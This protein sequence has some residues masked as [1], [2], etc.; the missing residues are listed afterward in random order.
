MKIIRSQEEIVNK[1]ENLTDDCFGTKRY[2]LIDYLDY[3]YAKEYLEDGVSADE[4]NNYLTKREFKTPLDE[5]V[6]YLPFALDKAESGRGLSAIRSLHH[7]E[8]WLW[9]IGDN[10]L[11]N[12]IENNDS[13]YGI[14]VLNLIKNKYAPDLEI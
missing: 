5:I 1:I 13:S 10:D 14:D 3:E 9:L 7:M 8:V 4:W 6:N 11:I 2:D 12:A